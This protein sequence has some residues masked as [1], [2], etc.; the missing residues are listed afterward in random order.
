MASLRRRLEAVSFRE[1]DEELLVLDTEFDRIH[2]LN[3]TAYFIYR[4]C[5]EVSSAEELA[6]LLASQYDVRQDIAQQD[7]DDTLSKLRAANL[8]VEV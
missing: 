5:E 1:V 4:N 8:I 7:V 6:S 2:Q 3:R